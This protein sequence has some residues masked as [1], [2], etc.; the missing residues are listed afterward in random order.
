M[1]TLRVLSNRRFDTDEA[2]RQF[3]WAVAAYHAGPQQLGTG[4]PFMSNEGDTTYW[5]IDSGNDWG[6]KFFPE[7]PDAF[8]INYRYGQRSE[9]GK[10]AE[11]AF[12]MWIANRFNAVE[13]DLEDT[14]DTSAPVA[15]VPVGDGFTLVELLV[16]IT[17]LY[18]FGALVLSLVKHFAQ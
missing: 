8:C 4:I 9:S 5:K 3:A 15:T 13:V 7:R 12:A 2:R 1:I 11:R 18:V 10:A 17:I 6:L 14:D 16:V